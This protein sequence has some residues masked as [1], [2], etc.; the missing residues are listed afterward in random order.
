[1]GEEGED[2]SQNE[3]EHCQHEDESDAPAVAQGGAAD[4]DS[5][6]DLRMMY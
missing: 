2:D 6:G 5:G 1:L 3:H 4:T